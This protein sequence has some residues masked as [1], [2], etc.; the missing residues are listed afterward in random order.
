MK[1]LLSL[2]LIFFTL[3]VSHAQDYHPYQVKSGKIEYELR[4]YK[5]LYHHS[6]NDGKERTWNEEKPYVAEIIVFYWDEFGDKTFEESWEVADYSGSRIPENKKYEILTSGGKKYYYNYH[7][8]EYKVLPDNIRQECMKR[9]N[10]YKVTGSWVQAAYGGMKKGTERILGKET[11]YYQA[12]KA[13]DIYTWKGVPLK[14]ETFKISSEGKRLSKGSTRIATFLKTG[15]GFDELV[16]DPERMQP[17]TAF[18][19]MSLYDI[20]EYLDAMP[21][22]LRQIGE[23]GFKIREGDVI[24]YVSSDMHLGKLKVLKITP[25]ELTI[26]FVTFAGDGSVRSQ[27]AK[28]AIPD[29]YTCDLD[30][31]R[32]SENRMYRQEFKYKYQNEPKLIPFPTLGFYLL[33]ESRLRQ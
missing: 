8:N 30:R 2:L 29:N 24:L 32:I 20:G 9:L 4:K 7:T 16:F 26:K 18:M 19:N 6:I 23:S 14:E 17:D 5:T 12:D 25:R 10:F 31:G 27:S 28:I 15:L 11:N 21:G 1:I 13:L 3:S 22:K 33:K